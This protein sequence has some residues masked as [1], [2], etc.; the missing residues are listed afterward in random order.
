MRKKRKPVKGLPTEQDINVYDSLDERAAVR[1][2][3]GKTREEIYVELKEYFFDCD[4]L[5]ESFYYLGP[6]AFAYYIPAWERLYAHYRHTESTEED[7]GEDSVAYSTLFFLSQRTLLTDND[8]PEARAAMLRLLSLCEQHYSSAH[9]YTDDE[10]AK[11]LRKCQKIRQLL[12][13][14]DQ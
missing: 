1:N 3:L 7:Y 8:T 2:F 10:R 6:K 14:A 12:N 13:T 5:V 4:Y 9:Y 11:A